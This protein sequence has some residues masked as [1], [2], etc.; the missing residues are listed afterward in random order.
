MPPAAIPSRSGA[1]SKRHWPRPSAARHRPRAPAT[2][3][4]EALAFCPGCGCNLEAE[5][6]VLIGE[7]AHDPRGFTRWRGSILSFTA[8]EHL[9]FGSLAQAGGAIVARAVLC[10]RVGNETLGNVIEVFMTRIRRKLRDAGA[11]A[12]IVQTVIGRGYRLNV[13]VIQC[14]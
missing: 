7:L 8:A 4:I 3:M 1:P 14:R 13:E 12:T 11:P 9:V 5:R 6:P 10:E 2:T